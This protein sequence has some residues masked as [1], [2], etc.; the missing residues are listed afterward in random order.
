MEKL[1]VVYHD[2]SRL[3][4][5]NERDGAMLPYFYK[6]IGYSP[7][8]KS[9]IIQRYPKKK[10]QPH[11]LIQNGIPVAHSFVEQEGYSV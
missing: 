10:Y 6:K 1:T 2:N 7:S 9:A 8:I 11:I 3:D 4:V 5:S